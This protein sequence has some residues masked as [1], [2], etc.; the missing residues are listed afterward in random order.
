M[1]NK[2]KIMILGA[3]VLQLPAILKA[4]EMGLEVIVVDMDNN[5]IG[6]NYAD[7]CLKF[8]TIDIPKVIVAAKYYAIDA[9]FTMASDMPMRTV[10]AVVK[11]LNLAGINEENALKATDKGLMRECLKEQNVPVPLFF[12]TSR[13]FDYLNII[14]YLPSKFIVKPADNS[15]SRG[16][17]LVG[18]KN[19]K[20]NVDYAFNYS[21]SYSRSGEVIVEEFMEGPEVSVETLSID[22]KVI[23]IAITDKITTGP[24]NFVELGHSQPSQLS[25]EIQKQIKDV[26]IRAV[27]AMGIIN[28]PSHTEIIVT[29][30]GPKIVELGARLGGDNITSHLTP[31]STGIDL[32]KCCIKIALGEKPYIEKK[33]NRAS[34]IRYFQGPVGK[35]KSISG[36]EETKN[37]KGIE[38]IKFVKSIGDNIGEIYSSS[39]RTGFII[40]QSH[41]VYDA[42]QKCEEV[43]SKIKIEIEK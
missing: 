30:K 39:D 41:S 10:A 15:G 7:I 5:A 43:L 4:K 18:D 12:K 36:I 1:N 3:S 21:K 26:A 25:H 35:I 17:F 37:I 2:K 31:L 19:N 29:N 28:G 32:V 24:P 42:I 27:K 16:I 8:S 11:E 23:V 14:E 22:G 6:F 40:T 38:E 20:Q 13:Y 34:A 9:I 33:I